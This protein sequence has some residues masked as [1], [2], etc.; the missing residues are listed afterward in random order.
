MIVRSDSEFPKFITYLTNDF[1]DVADVGPIVTAFKRYTYDEVNLF[2]LV[3]TGVGP[4]LSITRVEY[5]NDYV[6]VDTGLVEDEEIFFPAWLAR[7]FENGKDLVRVKAGRVHRAGAI[8]LK[9]LVVWA[10]AN[11]WDG[12]SRYI[13]AVNNSKRFVS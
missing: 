2:F 8:M 12:Q 3:A 5:D 9:M 6:G 11:Y 7:D 1:V 13:D 10:Y 4:K